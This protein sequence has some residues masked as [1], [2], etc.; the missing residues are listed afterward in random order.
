MYRYLNK[1]YF[2][3]MKIDH[4]KSQHFRDMK[5][6]YYFIIEGVH[7]IVIDESVYKKKEIQYYL[8]KICFRE[9]LRVFS[10]ISV[11]KYINESNH[12]IN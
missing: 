4:N 9:K 2:S 3:L 8:E 6:A 10:W 5:I 1:R 7:H 11:T 12:R